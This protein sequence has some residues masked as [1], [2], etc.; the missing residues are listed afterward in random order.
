MFKKKFDGKDYL[1]TELKKWGLNSV[2]VGGLEY[3]VATNLIIIKR[4]DEIA[5]LLKTRLKKE[6]ISML[7]Y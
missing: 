3:I 1:L 5:G 4:L 7:D 6:K 2:R